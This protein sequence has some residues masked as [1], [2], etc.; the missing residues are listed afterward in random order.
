MEPEVSQA[1]A[2]ARRAN[3]ISRLVNAADD[4]LVD[5]DDNEGLGEMSTEALKSYRRSAEITLKTLEK[6]HAKQQ[7]EVSCFHREHSRS[8]HTSLLPVSRRRTYNELTSL[9]NLLALVLTWCKGS[10]T[11]L[12]NST[13]QK[14]ALK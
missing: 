1:L 2:I 12:N 7:V 4:I 3:E 8:G 9:S 5:I 10:V 14:S 13:K 6:L 11:S